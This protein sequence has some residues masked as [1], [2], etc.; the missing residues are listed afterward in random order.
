[1]GAALAANEHQTGLDPS[2]VVDFVRQAISLVGNA[3]F[4]G[5]SDHR[6]SLLAKVSPESLDL[7]DETN[8][9]EKDSADLFGKKFKKAMLKEFKHDK[10]MDNLFGRSSHGNRKQFFRQQPGK[11]PGYFSRVPMPDRALVSGPKLLKTA[12]GSQRKRS[13]EVARQERRGTISR[14]ENSSRYFTCFKP[15]SGC[16]SRITELATHNSCTNGTFESF[17]N[18]FSR[19]HSASEVSRL[20]GSFC[21]KL[22][23]YFKRPRRFGGRCGLQT[24][25]HNVSSPNR[26]APRPTILKIGLGQTRNRDPI[27]A[28]KRGPNTSSTRSGPVSEQSFSS[29]QTG[30]VFAPSDQ[31]Q[32][33]EQFS[34]IHSFQD[35]GYP[36]SARSG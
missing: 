29:S 12:V 5:L 13:S 34:P 6:K 15:I 2:V 16:S 24:R 27:L 7:L 31:P 30:R 14:A 23:S 10:I 35:G 21:S 25:V 26:P 1:M 32:G 18:R 36:S 17:E 3:S 4:S 20:L 11:S 8:L 19:Y 33:F 9:F 22:A 28:T